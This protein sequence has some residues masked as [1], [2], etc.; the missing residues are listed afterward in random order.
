MAKML[1]VI[2]AGPLVM[3]TIYP[4][5]N[6]RDGD[7]IRAGKRQ[8]SSE[9]QR[10]MNLKYAYQRLE[11]E[12]AANFVERDLVTTFTYDYDHLPRDRRD[13]QRRVQRCWRR[14]RIKRAKKNKGLQY[15]YVTEHKHRHDN[16]LMDGRWHHHALINSTGDDYKDICEAWGQGSVD[17][18]PFRLDRE[19]NYETLARYFCKEQ[20]ERVGQRLWSCS[21]NLIKP[22]KDCFRV[23]NDVELVPPKGATI[24]MDTGDIRTAYGHYRFIK[25]LGCGGT[26]KPRPRARRSRRKS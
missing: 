3:Q 9:A 20:R 8:L 6:P 15:L 10:R 12:M 17:I 16:E 21:R 23:D 5:I 11:L 26:I 4:V 2:V 24:L 19:K 14:L 18:H 13:A 7:G 22:E 1:K 25:Y